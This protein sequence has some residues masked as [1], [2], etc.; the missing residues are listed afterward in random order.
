[1]THNQQEFVIKVQQDIINAQRILL[2]K[3]ESELPSGDS[4]RLQHFINEALKRLEDIHNRSKEVSKRGI[5]A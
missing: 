5:S 4:N 2:Q 1:M 3:H